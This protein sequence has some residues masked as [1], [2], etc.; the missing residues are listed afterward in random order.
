M[1]DR[2]VCDVCGKPATNAA[3]DVYRRDR[4]DGY[5]EN[6]PAEHVR[7]GCDDHPTESHAI[8]VS[9]VLVPPRNPW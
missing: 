9:T 1:N 5:V 4:W 2:P 6:T 7:H 3:C 8:D